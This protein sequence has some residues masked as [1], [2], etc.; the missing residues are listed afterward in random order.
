M[1]LLIVSQVQANSK[2]PELITKQDKKNIRFISDD[3]KFTYYQRV[4]GIF[5]FSTNYKVEEV[6]RLK[7]RTQFNI[8]ASP[9]LKYLILEADQNY[10]DYLSLTAK[11]EIYVI[12]YGTKNIRKVAEGIP[13]SL[14]L[15]DQYISYYNPN[16]RTLNIINHLNPSIKTVIK[17]AN[18][19]NPYF[20]PEVQMLDVD[21][22][23]Y[24]D[25]NKEGLPGVLLHKVNSSKTSV[26]EKLDTPNKRIEL[27]LNNDSLFT[28]EYGLDPLNKG[29][30]LS[31]YDFSKSDK[32]TANSLPEKN[33]I[34][35]SGENDL[36]SLKCNL[37]NEK[38]YIIKTNRTDEGKITTDA[39]EIDIK[40]KTVEILSD[41]L[42]ATNLV[43]MDGKLL[44][45]YQ[46]KHYVIKGRNN[47]TEFDKLK[48]KTEEQQ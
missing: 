19:L 30:T 25:I 44:L 32:R 34:Y 40:S 36:G 7:D 41:I 45:P 21:T 17:M 38:L 28:G 39:A 15:N 42:F 10:N 1:S 35:Q 27:C 14:H 48:A 3:G 31:Q 6:I 43:V 47:L 13:I 8:I 46:N 12:E 2:L 23:V 33:I 9:N 37:D 18:S 26:I 22:I 20:I 11:K 29:S 24:T 5:Q 4:N 16:E